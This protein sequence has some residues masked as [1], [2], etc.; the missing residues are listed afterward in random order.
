MVV[1]IVEDMGVEAAGMVPDRRI[2]PN[3]DLFSP[4]T[5][6]VLGISGH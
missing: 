2:R 4:R 1:A 3:F 6:P 5:W